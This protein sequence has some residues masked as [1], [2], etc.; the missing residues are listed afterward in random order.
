MFGLS[1]L[2]SL[3]IYA[4]MA[5]AAL[6][7]AYS[8]WSGFKQHIAAPYVA[9][10]IKADQKKVNAADTARAQAESDRQTAKDNVGRCEGALKT[11]ADAKLDADRQAAR[12]LTAAKEA[13]ARA[14]REAAA[15]A[16]R[17][18]QLQAIASAK[19]DQAK[20]CEQQ[21]AIARPILQEALR[22]GRPPPGPK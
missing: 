18:A 2:I 4:V 11:Q 7:F 1:P 14:D 10:Q 12:N 19:T 15:A 5:A 3:I 17:I 9:A 16:P 20:T 21:M 6:G 22:R 13:K 8:A